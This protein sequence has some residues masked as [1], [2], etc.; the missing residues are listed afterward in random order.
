MLAETLNEPSEF[1]AALQ[2]MLVMAHD[3]A[4]WFNSSSNDPTKSFNP[5]TGHDFGYSKEV[6][7]D[8]VAGS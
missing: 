3:G 8:L 4:F 6:L 2:F 5:V 1:F 7:T